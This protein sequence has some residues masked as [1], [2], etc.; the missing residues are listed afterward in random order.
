MAMMS[1][2]FGLGKNLGPVPQGKRRVWVHAPSRWA[3]FDHFAGDRRPRDQ[4]APATEVV[5]TVTTSTAF[6]LANEAECQ[7]LDDQPFRS[8]SGSSPVAHGSASAGPLGADGGRDVAGAYHQ[9]AMRRCRI[10]WQCTAF[11]TARGGRYREFMPLA[12][13]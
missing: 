12:V 9:A 6:A 8:I 1:G 11:Q 13:R 5:L 7:V 3:N 2:R 4:A 10:C